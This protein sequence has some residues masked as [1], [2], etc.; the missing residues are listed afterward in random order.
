MMAEFVREIRR[1]REP[2]CTGN[3]TNA[4]NTSRTANDTRH[5]LP[6]NSRNVGARKS[7]FLDEGPPKL[8]LLPIAKEQGWSGL[9]LKTCKGHSFALTSAAWALQ[10]DIELTL[11]DLTN[12]DYIPAIFAFSTLYFDFPP[13]RNRVVDVWLPKND[14]TQLV[15]LFFVHGGGWSNGYRSDAHPYDSIPGRRIR[16]YQR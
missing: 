3:I 6:F 7:V 5:R 12:T 15:S 16:L 8:D 13:I 4:N 2:V 9:A 14:A 1:Q 10:N 11:Q